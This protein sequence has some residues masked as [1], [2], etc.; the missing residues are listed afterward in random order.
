MNRRRTVRRALCAALTGLALAAVAPATIATAAHQIPNRVCDYDWRDGT[1]Q[2]KR[3]IRCAARRWDT[4]GAPT[5]A[6]TVA[7]C[8]SR[9]RPGAY[10]PGGFAGL[11]QQATRY[12][13][14]RARHYGQPDRSVYN[15]RAN[16]LVSIRMAASSNS[17]SAWAGCA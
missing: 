9:L 10:N 1:W 4:P 16:V 13:P 12:W 2:I 5:K 17:W 6:I 15:G 8:E 7:R 14:T 11:F 3:L